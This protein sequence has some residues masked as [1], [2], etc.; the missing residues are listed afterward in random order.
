MPD[1]DELAPGERL[2]DTAA[3][4]RWLATRGVR[5]SPQTLRKLRCVGGGPR[6]RRL[7]R[8]PYYREPDLAAWIEERLSAPVG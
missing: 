5:R 3:A 7:N 1:D 2:Y 6:F 8:Q 4:A